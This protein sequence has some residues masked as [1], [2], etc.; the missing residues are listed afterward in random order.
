MKTSDKNIS[1]PPQLCIIPFIHMG[2]KP[3]GV[4]RV[5]CMAPGLEVKEAH[6]RMLMGDRSIQ[7]AWNSDSMRAIRK[8]ML[9]GEKLPECGAC[10]KQEATGPH[11]K[12]LRENRK[13]LEKNKHRIVQAQESDGRVEEAPLYFDLRL[14]NR[15]NLRC[16]TCNPMFSS[17]W[18]AELNGNDM[19]SLNSSVKSSI[20]GSLD[21][22]NDMQ[23]WW[24]GGFFSQIEEIIPGL[25]EIYVSGGEPLLIS[26]FESFLQK[27][28]HMGYASQIDL[29]LNSNITIIKEDLLKNF[30]HFRKVLFGASVDAFGSKNDWMRNPSRWNLIEKN[31]K[32]LYEFSKNHSNFHLSANITVG[33]YNFFYL[34]EL[35]L[36]IK[37]QMPQVEFI[38]DFVNEPSY[39]SFQF[40]DERLAKEAVK[41][42]EELPIDRFTAQEQIYIGQLVERLSQVSADENSSLREDFFNHTRAVDQWRAESFEKVFPELAR[43]LNT[44]E[45]QARRAY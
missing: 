17:S 36:W 31:L 40:I 35:I 39:L 27:V 22:A 24:G 28:C 15:C 4:A 23:K 21:R 6:M 34:D 8:R 30:S 25:Q 10:W 38:F 16:R 29:R 14:G 37:E 18:Q 2:T 3:D 9:K 12:R 26:E 20:Q 11:S 1:T 19:S 45:P 13:Y 41:K 5:C 44:R 7:E 43:S 42:I 33:I 32:K